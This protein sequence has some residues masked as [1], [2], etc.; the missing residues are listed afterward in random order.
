MVPKS[1]KGDDLMIQGHTG[2]IGFTNQVGVRHFLVSSLFF[3]MSLPNTCNS[4]HCK[5]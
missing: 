1:Q 2:K 5:D 3:N 4:F